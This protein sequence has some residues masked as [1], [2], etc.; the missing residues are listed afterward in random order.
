M[1]DCTLFADAG[2]PS[3]SAHKVQSAAARHRNIS[4]NPVDRLPARL[5][6][7]VGVRTVQVWRIAA[8]SVVQPRGCPEIFQ[9]GHRGGHGVPVLG[10]TRGLPR[11]W[12]DW[13]GRLKMKISIRRYRNQELACQAHFG[14][15][16]IGGGRFS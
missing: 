12:Q 9:A 13:R 5:A 14:T 15:R 7:V 6:F 8:Y 16:G 10:P 1:Q 4:A 3:S 2:L 11:H